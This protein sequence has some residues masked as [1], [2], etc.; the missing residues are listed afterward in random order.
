[1]GQAN[2]PTG[3]FLFLGPTGVGKTELAKALALELFD[4]EKHMV[5][6]DMSEYMEAHSVS[7]MI[8]APPGY[9]GHEEGGQLTEAVRQ[10]PYNLILLDE[11]EKAH[12][13]VLDV[14]L[15]VLDDGRLTD[16]QGRTVD[17]ANT[18]LVMTSNIGA[19]ILLRAAD[20]VKDGRLPDT[21]K[22]LVMEKVT[23]P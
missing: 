4:D 14:L 10:R 12:G 7:R 16:S 1:M 15:Q 18:V 23:L 9:V 17:F 3:A 19:D 5:R 2:R 21:T 13:K 11:I 8:G 22:E 6:I 20:H